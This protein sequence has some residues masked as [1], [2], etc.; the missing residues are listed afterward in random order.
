MK[1]FTINLLSLTFVVLFFVSSSDSRIE[2]TSVPD[3]GKY[4]RIAEMA[5]EEFMMTRDP[6]TNTV[7]KEKLYKIRKAMLQSPSYQKSLADDEWESR[8]PNDVG[9]RTR[10][11]IIDS[12]DSTGNT[13]FVGSVAGGLWKCTNAMLAP[14]WERVEGYVGNPSISSWFKILIILKLCM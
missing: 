7:P 4:H 6:E 14:T 2:Q 13:L 10:A 12:R 11:L 9:G 3:H 8:G 1:L 5:E